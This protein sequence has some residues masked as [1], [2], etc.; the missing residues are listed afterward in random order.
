MGS[1][2][3]ALDACAGASRCIRP[4]LAD[5]DHTVASRAQCKH[6]IWVVQQS[7]KGCTERMVGLCNPASVSHETTRVRAG[8]ADTPCHMT[9]SSMPQAKFGSEQRNIVLPSTLQRAGT[10]AF[11]MV[12]NDAHATCLEDSCS[13]STSCASSLQALMRHRL[14]LHRSAWTRHL[15]C[16]QGRRARHVICS[17]V[18]ATM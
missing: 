12:R 14:A 5:P 10:M 11:A 17:L 4:P 3:P 16:M 7:R 13:V 18:K 6:H 1:V 15:W 9:C 2:L 8:P